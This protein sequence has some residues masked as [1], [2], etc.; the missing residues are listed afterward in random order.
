M[1]SLNDTIYDTMLREERTFSSSEIVRRFFKMTHVDEKL[2]E[3]IVC[4]VLL[5]DSRFTRDSGSAWRIL[6]VQDSEKAPVETASFVLFYIEDTQ[7]MLQ[8]VPDPF[9]QIE[10]YASFIIRKGTAD[11]EVMDVRDLL[12]DA[13]NIYVPYDAGSLN[14]LKTL[15]RRLSPLEPELT[16]LSVKR[17][18]SHLY[19]EKRIKGWQDLIREFSLLNYESHSSLSKTKT[20]LQV[21]VHIL[22]TA[23][24]RGAS[25]VEDLLEMSAKPKKQ[26]NFGQYGFDRV[27][28][29]TLPS[30][31][32]VYI[33]RNREGQVIYIGKTSNLKS[34]VGSYFR[35]SEESVEKRALILHHLYSIE[36][37]ELGSDLES[38]IEEYRLIDRYRPVMNTK[39]G[40][41]R[42]VI[43]TP[44]TILVLPSASRNG[45]KLYFVS[46]T[47][48][49]VECD[50]TAGAADG[51]NGTLSKDSM[52]VIGAII[53]G[54]TK[55]T[56]YVFDP[57]KT[58]AVNYWKQYDW[59][60]NTIDIGRFRSIEDIGFVLYTFLEE[61]EVIEREKIYYV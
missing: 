7:D 1:K 44:D 15:Y 18:V 28:L 43:E 34:R 55:G 59:R 58:I 31:P 13:D 9:S 12:L 47:S 40:V 22:D 45:L 24:A 60:V 27:F 51:K 6:R 49:L 53:E 33:F 26:I 42:R 56:E 37:T 3:R 57:L 21:F 4:P 35:D 5:A 11:T 38:L 46:N 52:A 17:L 16:V 30:S 29:K 2:A 48:P 20:L 50:L 61:I 19:P 10:K 32:G 23:I 25:V 36:Y 41:S 8:S 54:L 14:R 39:V